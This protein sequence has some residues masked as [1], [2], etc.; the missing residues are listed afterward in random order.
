MRE[1]KSKNRLI[2][3]L[4]MIICAAVIYSCGTLYFS[5]QGFIYSLLSIFI[6]LI[7]LW[8]I[9]PFFDISKNVL[10]GFIIYILVH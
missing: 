9:N 4:L 2:S 7:V 10:I 6:S 5:L 8:L 3:F 1:E